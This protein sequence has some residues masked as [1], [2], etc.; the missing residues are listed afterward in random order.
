MKTIDVP[1][2][3]LQFVVEND[4]EEYRV[5]SIFEKEPETI[6]WMNRFNGNSVFFDIGANI[7][8]YTLYSVSRH[9][10]L[11]VFAF[12]PV[13]N[14][15]ASLLRNVWANNYANVKSF[16]VALSDKECLTELFLSDLRI[17]NS[18]AQINSPVDDKGGGFE[19]LRVEKVL[20]VSVDRLIQQFGFPV[21]SYV[22]IDVD[23]HESDILNGMISTLRSESFKSLLVEF[24]S[25]DQFTYWKER[26]AAAGLALDH[27][28][29]NVPN[30]SGVRR[31]SK[32]SVA[33]NYIFSR[34]D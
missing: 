5:N 19:A 7:G 4:L 1:N 3:G 16:H 27:G 34:P 14:N 28:F 21:P 31:Q 30:H 29:D 2:H 20:C 32:G 24:N 13:S 8:I 6:E 11:S 17:G 22:K 23:G 18:G 12:E 9:H 15:Y 26:L 33:R 10:D 25:Q